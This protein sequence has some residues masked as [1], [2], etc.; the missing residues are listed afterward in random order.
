MR[1]CE[2]DEALRCH[3]HSVAMDVG[4]VNVGENMVR[5]PLS[6]S[7]VMGDS[8]GGGVGGSDGNGGERGVASGDAAGCTSACS[9]MLSCALIIAARSS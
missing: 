5:L 6:G 1:C 3:D 9:C 2:A 8:I 7:T 4:D